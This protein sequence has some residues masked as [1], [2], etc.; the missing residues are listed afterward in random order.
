M[1]AN[2]TDLAQWEREVAD[3]EDAHNRAVVDRMMALVTEVRHLIG[4]AEVADEQGHPGLAAQI[5]EQAHAVQ[6]EIER[7]MSEG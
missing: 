6:A 7:L 4:C 5:R 1:A 2:D 3:V